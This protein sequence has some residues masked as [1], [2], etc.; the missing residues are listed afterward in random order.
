MARTVLHYT[1]RYYTAVRRPSRPS[2]VADVAERPPWRI[3]G[4]DFVGKHVRRFYGGEEGAELVVGNG[5]IVSWLP[6]EGDDPALWHV[7]S[8]IS[9]VSVLCSVV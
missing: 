7:V 3:E 8:R 2:Q 5:V 1:I 6:P 4:H 9:Y